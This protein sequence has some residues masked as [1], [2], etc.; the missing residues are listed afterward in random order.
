MPKT[1]G[2]EYIDGKEILSLIKITDVVIKKNP[3]TGSKFSNLC[4]L[5]L[6]FKWKYAKNEPDNNSQILTF[7]K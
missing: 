2:I 6:L 1:T 5:F 4:D 7:K 3:I